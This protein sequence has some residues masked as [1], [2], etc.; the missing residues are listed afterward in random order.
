MAVRKL[1]S[2]TSVLSGLEML[3]RRRGRK[4]KRGAGRT[5][6][7]KA[8]RGRKAGSEWV[9]GETANLKRDA[10]IVFEFESGRG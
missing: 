3:K 6:R 2:A 9:V 4:L 7:A 5:S 1:K 8:M 10:R